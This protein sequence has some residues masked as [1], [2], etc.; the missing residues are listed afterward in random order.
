MQLCLCLDYRA[1]GVAVAL[2]CV[3]RLCVRR[4]I[5]I[6]ICICGTVALW[7][8]AAGEVLCKGNNPMAL[9]PRARRAPLAG[10]LAVAFWQRAW[11]RVCWSG[12]TCSSASCLCMQRGRCSLLGCEGRACSSLSPQAQGHPQGHPPSLVAH[13]SNDV[14]EETFPWVRICKLFMHL[15]DGMGVPLVLSR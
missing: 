4:C 12:R 14:R 10:T 1:V 2:F 5:C 8:R 15:G 3:R 9:W 6:C 11:Q 13:E 7:Q